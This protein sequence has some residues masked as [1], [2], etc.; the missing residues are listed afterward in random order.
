MPKKTKGV[1]LFG[2]CLHEDGGAA[3]SKDEGEEED[4]AEEEEEDP[5]RDGEGQS[6]ERL[7]KDRQQQQRPEQAL[8]DREN[9]Q[10]A[11]GELRVANSS[12]ELEK[13]DGTVMM[14]MKHVKTVSQLNMAARPTSTL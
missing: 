8:R 14:A 4:L 7:P 5:Q 1:C 12:W 2:S 3:Q 9:N 10:H 11:T 6:R 13:G